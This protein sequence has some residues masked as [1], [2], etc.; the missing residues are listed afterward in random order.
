MVER[1]FFVFANWPMSRSKDPSSEGAVWYLEEC[2]KDRFSDN[3][4][5]SNSMGGKI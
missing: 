2:Y 1:V 3:E 4:I 5:V